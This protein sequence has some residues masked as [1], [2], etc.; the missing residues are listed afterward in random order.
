MISSTMYIGWVGGHDMTSIQEET[1]LHQV[2]IFVD[3]ELQ[4]VIIF[5]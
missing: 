5:Q 3:Y 1:V 4:L 2:S